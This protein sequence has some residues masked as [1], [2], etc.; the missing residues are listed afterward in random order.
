M[1]KNRAKQ[2]QQKDPKARCV[3]SIKSRAFSK[4]LLEVY[5]FIHWS[6]LGL[7]P[8]WTSRLRMLGTLLFNSLSG[9]NQG[10]RTWRMAFN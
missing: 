1:N 2:R 7:W 5:T 3:A 4:F 6:E 9:R 10:K 8:P